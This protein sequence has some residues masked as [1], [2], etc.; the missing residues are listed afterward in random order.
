MPRLGLQ[1]VIVLLRFCVMTMSTLVSNLMK[2]LSIEG[3]PIRVYVV[4]R[5]LFV[6]T[7]IRFPLLQ[8]KCCAP[9]TVWLCFRMVVVRLVVELIWIQ[10]VAARFRLYRKLPLLSWLRS[11]VSV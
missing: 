9:R 4:L 8:L 7:C 10:G 1:V 6:P 5:L 11:M 2:F 3:V